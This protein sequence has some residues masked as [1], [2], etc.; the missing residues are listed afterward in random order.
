MKKSKTVIDNLVFHHHTS[1]GDH[2]ICNG[3]AHNYAKECEILHIPCSEGNYETVNSLYSDF[4]NII[5]HPMKFQSPISKHEVDALAAKE[6]WEVTR[7]G[8]EKV[9][10]RRFHRHNSPGVEAI[11]VN[12]DRQFYEEADLLYRK[13][14]EDFHL[15]ENIPDTDKVYEKLVGDNERYIVV[16]KNSSS[17]SDYPIELWSWRTG[18]FNKNIKVV[19]IQMGQTTNMLAYK[20]LIENAEEVHCVPS[21]FFCLVDSISK[22]IKP[23]LYYHDI[24]VNNILQ[25]NCAANNNKWTSIDYSFKL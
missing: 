9:Y 11:P 3:I 5:V 10:Y 22:N 8:F 15:P 16:H 23:S 14:Y 20:K 1:L 13:R 4:D 17:S 21:A 12:F 19:E 18:K 24:R 25:I 2:F 6:G 7:I